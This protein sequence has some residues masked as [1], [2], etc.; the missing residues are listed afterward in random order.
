[1]APPADADRAT[2]GN[3]TLPKKA[4]CSDGLCQKINA[5]IQPIWL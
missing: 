2:R 4:S 5:E 1:M 3:S